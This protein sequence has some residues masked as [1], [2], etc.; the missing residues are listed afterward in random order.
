MKYAIDM[1]SQADV[2]NNAKKELVKLVRHDYG[3]EVGFGMDFYFEMV[4]FSPEIKMYHGLN[5]LIIH[6][7]TPFASSID[8]LNSKIFVISFLFE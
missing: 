5:N 2:T 1:A 3:Y 4:K 8:R 7:G 6:D